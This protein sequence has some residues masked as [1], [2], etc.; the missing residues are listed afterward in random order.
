MVIRCQRS[1]TVRP[2]YTIAHYLIT[3]KLGEGGMGEVW[4]ATDTR[5]NRD[6]AIKI[7]PQAFTQDAD[8]LARFTR[9]AQVLAALNHPNIA[10]IYGVEE[11]ALIMELV[12]GATLA[13]RIS[14]G[15]IPP[16]EA[17]PIAR[18][19]AESL[20]Y[21]HERGI[22]HRD[23]KPA[24]IKV[25]PDGRVKVLDF[26]LAKALSSETAA[27]RA[28]PSATLTMDATQVGAIVGTAAYMSPEQATRQPAD[29]RAD[30][31]SFGAVVYE[32]LV[33]KRAFE[34]A[35][36]S[37]TLASVLKVEPHWEALPSATPA[38]IRQ[39]VRRCLVRDRRQRLQ[40]IGEARIAL[41][42]PATGET[43]QA[44]VPSRSKL[45][46]AAMAA[47]A[48]FF[49]IAALLAFLH[50]R[51][52]PPT[53]EVTR[54]QIAAPERSGSLSYP[55]ISPNGRMIAFTAV[56]RGAAR[57]MLWVRSLDSL[58]ALSL[59]GTENASVPFWSPDSRFLAFAQT[60]KLKKVGVPGDAP[61]ALCDFE[62][63]WRGGVWSSRGV[64]VF[65]S[66]GH[67]LMRVS[68]AGGSAV[69][70]TAIDR[71]RKEIYHLGP[72][73]LP[74]GSHFL[75][76]RVSF[77]AENA[78]LYLGSLDVEPAHQKTNRL[79]IANSFRYAASPDAA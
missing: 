33:G 40:A 9:E 60:G 48:L 1:L 7:L 3:A 13:E 77:L 68:E 23:L 53:A 38:S 76:S 50:F 31:W 28:E 25:T 64:I 54:F 22:I 27:G 6:V 61:Q 66:V 41:E 62:G 29:R 15:P 16:E 10:A 67:G 72:A 52:K 36:V 20:E 44:N 65:G 34:G 43:A 37:E 32:M 21:A 47:A 19:I 12:D 59:P 30:I 4:R 8:R 14:Q 2:Q 58:E 11:H 18:Q 55:V 42:S 78:G 79:A 63:D 69:P 39:L 5:L 75:Y 24:N 35:S 45:G 46:V 71:S 26:G 73:F 56:D 74:D 57:G 51:E 17:L 49:V 70:V